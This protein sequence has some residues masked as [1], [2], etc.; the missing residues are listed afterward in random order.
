[1]ETKKQRIIWLD[2]LKAIAFLF[3]IIGHLEISEEFKS[4]IYSFHM[5]LFFFISGFTMNIKKTYS[6]PFPEYFKKISKRI[7]FP[8]FWISLVI[9]PFKYLRVEYIEHQ[10]MPIAENIMGIFVSHSSLCQMVS[11]PLYFLTLLFLA[12][13]LLWMLI[14]LSKGQFSM[15]LILSA[16]ILPV[17]LC[18]IDK[19]MPWHINVVPAAV[20]MMCIGKVLKNLYVSYDDKIQ[21]CSI[22]K[23][24][25]AGFLFFSAGYWIWKYNGRISIFGNIYGE[26]FFL[27][28]L[29]AAA[30]SCALAMIVMK[31]PEI[32]V[33]TYFG[34]NTL[35]YLGMHYELIR[36]LGSFEEYEN[37]AWF[38]AAA[39][40][41]I[42]V[43]LV[44]ISLIIQ[45]FQPYVMGIPIKRETLPVKI[46]K[47]F[48]VFE[49]TVVFFITTVKKAA[50]GFFSS[51]I[52][53]F[54]C[55][56]IIYLSLCLLVTTVIN[57]YFPV[58]FM[59]SKQ[60]NKIKQHSIL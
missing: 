2:Q 23:Y 43:L 53:S 4:W 47:Y 29:S 57:K 55:S 8:Y 5:P 16:S 1:M 42:S 22:P 48:S 14:K 40:V 60:S 3:V 25:L 12:Q 56:L 11:L 17:S 50:N 35:L 39:T 18:T 46:G 13:L 9:L 31:L 28:V 10:E 24:L 45:K 41:V 37:K 21:N 26:D 30:T 38:I 54:I 49:V 51:S 15:V 36:L 33:L 19:P 6:T 32:K 7:L 34:Q 27:C 44:L 59:Q 52:I 20:F 58:I